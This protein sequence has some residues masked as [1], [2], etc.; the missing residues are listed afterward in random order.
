M[1]LKFSAADPAFRV[2][3]REFLRDRLPR[4]MAA[5]AYAGFTP[6]PKQDLVDW[7]RIL[8]EKGWAAPHWPVEHG[9]TGQASATT[10]AC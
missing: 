8:F 9:G 3:V 5:R 2:E 7:N 4:D 10:I 6:P 1:N